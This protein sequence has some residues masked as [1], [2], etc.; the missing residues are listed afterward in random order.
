MRRP[1]QELRR[2]EP[3]LAQDQHDRQDQQ[4]GAERDQEVADAG[5]LERAADADQEEDRGQEDGNPDV[6]VTDQAGPVARVELRVSRVVVPVGLRLGRKL[7]LRHV[8]RAGRG[9]RIV[10]RVGRH[11]RVEGNPEHRAEASLGDCLLLRAVQGERDE[12]GV[13][14]RGVEVALRQRREVVA[15]GEVAQRGGPGDVD[16]GCRSPPCRR[17]PSPGSGDRDQSQ[18]QGLA[19]LNDPGMAGLGSMT[20][21]SALVRV[22]LLLPVLMELLAGLNG[23]EPLSHLR[24]HP[25]W[26]PGERHRP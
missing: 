13:E 19:D 16:A 15:G 22:L 18:Q 1:G 2:R 25:R 24:T 5:Q 12:P 26:T 11:P 14:R 23:I 21:F 10:Q 3:G 8:S 9:V 7:V 17:V 20:C 6:V 4:H